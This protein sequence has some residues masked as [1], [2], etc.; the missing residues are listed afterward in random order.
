MDSS[1]GNFFSQKFSILLTSVLAYNLSFTYHV[2]N[3][4]L[5][6]VNLIFYFLKFCGKLAALV[7]RLMSSHFLDEFPENIKFFDCL[8]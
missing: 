5:Y 4:I 7:L 8:L 3:K 6:V 2:L 1:K